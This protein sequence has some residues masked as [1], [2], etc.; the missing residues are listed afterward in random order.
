MGSQGWRI[1]L[2]ILLAT[3]WGWN[4]TIGK[5][6]DMRPNPGLYPMWLWVTLIAID[7]VL[8]ALDIWAIMAL[9]NAAWA[10]LDK[11]DSGPKQSER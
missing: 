1:P 9:V 11:S 2:A 4:P 3:V 6:N 10:Y 8:L 5:L 7:V